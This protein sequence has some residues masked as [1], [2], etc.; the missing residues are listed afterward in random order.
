MTFRLAILSVL[1]LGVCHAQEPVFIDDAKIEQDFVDQ[2]SALVEKVDTLTMREAESAVKK[3][4]SRKVSITEIPTKTSPETPSSLYRQCAPSVVSI[5]SIF[6]CEKCDEWHHGGAASG[7]IAS[8]EG[9]IVTNAHLFEN[10]KDDPL[11]VMTLDGGIFPVKEIVAADVEKDIAILRINPGNKTL[12]AL[13]LANSA[14]PAEE[15][16]VISHPQ[17]QYYCLTSGKIS[18]FHRD[19]LKEDEPPTDWMSITADF[20]GGSSGGPVLNKNGEVVGMVAS[21]LTAYSEASDCKTHPGP[22]VQ[23]VFKDCIPLPSLRA[24]FQSRE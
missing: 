5:G 9:L 13:P 16:H 3:N 20:A 24:M 19:Q 21:T 15:V 6:K 23:M 1:F 22:D 18:R 4:P 7:W 2:L 8:P 14:E 12:R 11:A 17:G 10:G